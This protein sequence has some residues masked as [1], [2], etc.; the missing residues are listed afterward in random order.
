[1][2]DPSSVRRLDVPSNVI[3]RPALG[4]HP[5][6]AVT[7]A[8]A[9]AEDLLVV[10]GTFAAFTDLFLANSWVGDDAYI[11]FRGVDNF[12]HGFGLRWNPVERVQAF[13]S[14]LWLL[15]LSP[16]YAVSR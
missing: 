9:R 6:S 8:P 4:T 1:M 3:S 12:I 16:F 5:E 2:S 11:T 14:P 7:R 10:V 13:T 15:F